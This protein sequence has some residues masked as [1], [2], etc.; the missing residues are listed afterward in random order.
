VIVLILSQYVP[1]PEAIIISLLARLLATIGDAI[2]A[3]IYL[4]VRRT[5]PQ[6]IRP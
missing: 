1:A 2:V 3:L 6:E 4:I 5:L